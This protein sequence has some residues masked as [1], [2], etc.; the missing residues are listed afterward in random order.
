MRSQNCL[1][2]FFQQKNTILYAKAENMEKHISYCGFRIL[3]LIQKCMNE[4]IL[5]K[6]DQNY[7][8]VLDSHQRMGGRARLYHSVPEPW[9]GTR[10]PH[11]TASTILTPSLPSLDDRQHLLVLSTPQVAGFVRGSHW[12]VRSV[13][14]FPLRKVC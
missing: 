5:K 2:V 9:E 7:C 8:T 3:P 12:R 14:G 13:R 1:F 11:R 4:L 10:T 6:K